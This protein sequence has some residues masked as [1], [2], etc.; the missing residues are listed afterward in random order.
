MTVATRRRRGRPRV[1][2]LTARRR[3]EILAAATRSF[4]RRGFSATDLQVVADELGMGKGTIYRYF[5]TKQA[6]F[7]AAV[8]QAM[9]RIGDELHGIAQAPSDPLN[10]IVDAVRAYLRFFDRNPDVIEL[11]IQERAEFKD[12]KKPTYFQHQEANLGPW[13]ALLRGLIAAGRVRRIPVAR[14]VDVLSDLLYGTIFTNYFA[15]RRKSFEAQTRDILDIAFHGILTA[16][17]GR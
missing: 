9:R 2:G 8:D 6:L 13:Q 17:G 1:A 12:R 16:G 3:G 5:A 7:L 11:L 4:A 10:L 15:G 14:I